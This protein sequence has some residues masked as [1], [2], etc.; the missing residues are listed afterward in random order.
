[1]KVRVYGDAAVVIGRST[2]KGQSKGEAFTVLSAWTD[3]W[4]KQAGRWRVVAE[5]VSAIPQK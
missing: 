3:T 4:I 1:M 5:H 2:E